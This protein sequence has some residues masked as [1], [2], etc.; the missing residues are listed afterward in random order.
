[1]SERKVIN[2]YY[3][4]D[5]D[6]ALI[7]RGKRPKND[8]VKVRMMMPM[9]VRCNTCGE[10]IYRGKKFNSRKETVIG[11][12]YYGIKIFRFYMRCP[13]CAAEFTIKTDPKNSDYVAE[14]NCSRNFEP[15]RDKEQQ[16]EDAKKKRE[17]EEEGDAMKALENRTLDSKIEMDIIDALDEIRALN[18]RNASID[19]DTLITEH[20]KVYDEMQRRLA[21]RD[22]AELE[23]IVFKNSPSYV[24]RVEEPIPDSAILSED[25]NDSENTNLQSDDINK[26]QRRK[27]LESS[28]SEIHSNSSPTIPK[29]LLLIDYED[30]ESK[31]GNDTD[32]YCQETDHSIPRKRTKHFE[33]ESSELGVFNSIDMNNIQSKQ[34]EKEIP[35]TCSAP[36]VTDGTTPKT[37]LL[38]WIPPITDSKVV[39]KPTIMVLPKSTISLKSSVN[40]TSLV[41]Y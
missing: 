16:M 14:M 25:E 37:S 17:S 30:E 22:E 18:Q 10:Y 6:P 15:W 4:P 26:E 35:S 8:Q 19:A 34:N 20:R 5:F 9:S 3:P 40:L 11:V 7:P 41:D 1:M 39:S 27:T 36:S 33:G 32:L 28:T 23:G 38:R 13:R 24:R 29:S 31:E 12:D 21:E 2:K